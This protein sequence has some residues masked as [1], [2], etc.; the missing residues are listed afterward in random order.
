MDFEQ[1]TKQVEE[2][3]GKA[4]DAV[5]RLEKSN[6]PEDRKAITK[7]IERLDESLKPLVVEHEKAMRDAEVKATREQVTTLTAAI[8]DLQRKPGPEDFSFGGSDAGDNGAKAIYGNESEYSFYADVAASRKGDQKAIERL[9]ESVEGKAMTVGTSSAG[10]YLVPDQYS[11]EVL[12]LRFQIAVLEPLF[13]RINVTSD[14]LRIASVTGGLT[15]GWV[16]ELA[17]KPAADLTFG[18]IST[19]VFTVAGLAVASNQ[20]LSYAGSQIDRLV[21]TE[22]ARRINRVIE[23]A[24]LNGSG[25]GQPKGILGTSGVGT[26]ALTSTDVDDLLDAISDAITAIYTDFIDAPNA[27]VMHPRTWGRIA[28]AR[29]TNGAYLIGS[30][31]AP[32]QDRTAVAGLPGYSGGQTPRGELFG[33][34]VYTTANVPTDLGTGTD[35]SRVIVGKFDEGLVLDRGGIT[36]DKSEHVYFTSNQT[37][38]RGEQDIGF[39]AA[40]YPKAFNVIGGV[41]LVDG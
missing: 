14:T 41:G 20:L 25:T 27:I 16:A 2:L 32:R 36:V 18:E 23:I 35:E 9:N 40:R 31:T 3:Q 5:E 8:E 26:T 33:L 12:D 1:I 30:A 22:L 6:D 34:P 15:A 11:R 21:N 10:G 24:I 29:D 37:I 7:E 39:T 4:A 13:S 19:G 28:K 38:F 17:E